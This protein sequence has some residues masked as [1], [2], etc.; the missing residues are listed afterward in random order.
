MR[1]L[2][3]IIPY[4]P[5]PIQGSGEVDVPVL[6][7]L[8]NDLIA[9][10]VH[11]LCVLGSSGEFA[12]LTFEQKVTVVSASVR[13]SSGR[14]PVVAGVCGTS[15][16]QAVKEAKAFSELQID[17]IVLILQTYFPLKP[18]DMVNFYSAV[19]SAVPNLPIVLYTNPSYMHF[20]ISVEVLEQLATV[21][22]IMYIKDAS[23]VT[24]RLL[25]FANRFG[26]RFKIFSA[27][28]HVPLFVFQLGG[29]GWM[30]GPA[31]LIPRQSVWL[32]ELHRQGRY[33]EALKLQK[34]LWE[35][36]R[37]FVK[38]D[39]VACVKAGLEHLGYAVGTPISPL[40]ALSNDALEEV[41]SI[42]DS[43]R[44]IE[45]PL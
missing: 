23:G 18:K 31:C 5:S 11:G 41:C 25:S 30:A 24:G 33:D 27:S 32:Y 7:R 4:L 22:N 13:A 6:T 8:C 12:Y 3:G 14:V 16:M 20:D 36:N 1:T 42:V 44:S 10:G 26:D 45:T 37:T 35:M 39:L 9:D 28:A 19:A 2:H 43:L 40:V 15:V 17:G 21:P 29:V 38:Y 34:H